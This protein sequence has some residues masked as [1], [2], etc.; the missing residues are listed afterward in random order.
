L[1]D[2]LKDADR[3]DM[4]RGSDKKRLHMLDGAIEHLESEGT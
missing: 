2:P 3:T 1:I 4:T